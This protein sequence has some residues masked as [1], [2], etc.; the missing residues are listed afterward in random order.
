MERVVRLIM[1]RDGLSYE[2]AKTEVSNT[3]DEMYEA[4]E[5]G[6][7]EQVEEIL[8][9]NLGLEPDYIPQLLGIF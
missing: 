1:K 7:S 9:D 8:M 4:L 2:D 5:S 6:D 3:V